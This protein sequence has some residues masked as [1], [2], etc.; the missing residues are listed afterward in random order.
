VLEQ[1]VPGTAMPAWKQ[2]TADQRHLLVRYVQ[3]FYADGQ[4]QGLK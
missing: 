2:L 1:G 3:S 4:E